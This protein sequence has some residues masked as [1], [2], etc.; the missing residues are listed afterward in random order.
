MDQISII[1]LVCL[2]VFYPLSFIYACN[3]LANKQQKKEEEEEQQ[4]Q[5]QQKQQQQQQKRQQE[6]QKRQQAINKYINKGILQTSEEFPFEGR[7]YTL[8]E[9]LKSNHFK[10]SYSDLNYAA[11]RLAVWLSK[12][13]PELIRDGRMTLKD[14]YLEISGLVIE[15][16]EINLKYLAERISKSVVKLYDETE[17]TVYGCGKV[18]QRKEV[19]RNISGIVVG[20]DSYFSNDNSVKNN[21]CLVC[22]FE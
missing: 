21:I 7:E 19:I 1:I 10:D 17:V 3:S 4:Q 13:K 15:S 9:V 2:I 18:P 22:Y 14:S 6:E 11:I 12:Q 8:I 20:K 5:Q 16:S